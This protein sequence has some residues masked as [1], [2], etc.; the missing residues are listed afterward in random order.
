MKN[1]CVESWLIEELD[2]WTS[3]HSIWYTKQ[4]NY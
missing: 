2:L 1:S 4:W 3:K